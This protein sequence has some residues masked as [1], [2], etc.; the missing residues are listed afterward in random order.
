MPA[1][2][3]FFWDE[4]LSADRPWRSSFCAEPCTGSG[5]IEIIDLS[6]RKKGLNPNMGSGQATVNTDPAPVWDEEFQS[7][8]GKWT[9]Q[10]PP[11]PIGV[12]KFQSQYGKW[13]DD[14]DFAY[15]KAD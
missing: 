2:P 7:Q 11:I 3:V 14:G 12:N 13:T 15:V 9:D 4:A 1:M 5:Q 10:L 6:H 8:Y